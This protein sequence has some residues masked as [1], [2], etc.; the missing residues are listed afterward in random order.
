MNEKFLEL[1]EE[2]QMRIINAGFEVFSQNDYK[3]ASTE[4]IA[5]KA[6]I[7]KGLLFYYFHNKK[8]LYLFLY[9][10]AQNHLK[11]SVLDS[12]FFEITDV[13][14]LFEYAA[15]SKYTLL[16]KSPHI[17]DF[18]MRSFYSQKEDVSDELNQRFCDASAEI[19]SSFLSKMD[20]SKFRNDINPQE[21][22]QMLIWMADGYLHE[23]QRLGLEFKLEDMMEKYRIWT[24]LL[25]Q[26]SYKEEYRDERNY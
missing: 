25:K 2:K 3:R 7:S 17:A 16:R 1:P 18:V 15:L 23:K 9:E 26:I 14:E 12:H 24:G 20:Y 6:G 22:L 19:F 8:S 4:Q 13:F 5:A 11:E 21:I 10:Y